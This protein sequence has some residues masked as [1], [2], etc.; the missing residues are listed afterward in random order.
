MVE[1]LTQEQIAEIREQFA[2]FDKGIH[3]TGYIV[4][5]AISDGDGSIT[6]KEVSEIIRSLGMEA[7]EGEIDE[8]IRTFDIDGNG[9]IDFNE[10]LEGKKRELQP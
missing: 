10:F 1:S 9:E 6:T 5:M 3:Y 2:L 7:D 4:F 8:M